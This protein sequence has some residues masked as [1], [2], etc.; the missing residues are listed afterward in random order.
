MFILTRVAHV[1]RTTTPDDDPAP[2][3]DGPAADDNDEDEGEALSAL[4]ALAA[5]PRAGARPERVRELEACVRLQRGEQGAD[6]AVAAAFEAADGEN[7]YTKEMATPMCIGLARMRKACE[8]LGTTDKPALGADE[9][10]KL[11]ED[12]P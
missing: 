11:C 4:T 12:V 10:A 1:E 3:D 8:R 6:A 7:A 5:P 2:Y 9:L